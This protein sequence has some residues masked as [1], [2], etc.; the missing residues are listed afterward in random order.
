MGSDF[1]AVVTTVLC[2]SDG[3]GNHEC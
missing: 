3:P 1:I 2:N